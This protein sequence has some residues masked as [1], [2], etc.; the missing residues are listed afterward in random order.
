[1]KSPQQARILELFDQASDLETTEQEAFLQRTCGDDPAL[2]CEVKRLLKEFS[3][4]DEFLAHSAISL[5]TRSLSQE[6]LPLLPGTRLGSYE[7]IKELGRGGM[8]DVFQAR[9][10]IGLPVAIKVLPDYYAQDPERVSRFE[11]EA[12]KMAQLKHPNIAGIHG[13][14]VED[15]W[16]FL[17]LEYVEGETLEARLERGALTVRE[18]VPIFSQIADALSVTHRKD[19]VHRDL[20]PSNIMLT[21]TG[22]VKLLDFGIAKHFRHEETASQQLVDDSM[23]TTL[24]KN[25]TAFGFTPGTLPYM[26]PEQRASEKTD[27]ATDIWAFGV[28]MYEAL[29]GHHP[30]RRDTRDETAMAIAFATPSWKLLPTATP[31]SVRELLKRCLV[32]DPKLRFRDAAEAKQILETTQQD[33]ERGKLRSWLRQIR[34]RWAQRMVVSFACGAALLSGFV[35]YRVYE[36]NAL[37]LIVVPS[38]KPPCQPLQTQELLTRLNQLSRLRVTTLDQNS[39]AAQLKLLLEPQC[40]GNASKALIKLVLP[41]ANTEGLTL[42]AQQAENIDQAMKQLEPVLNAMVSAKTMTTSPTQA[43]TN[44]VIALRPELKPEEQRTLDLDEWDDKASLEDAIQTVR[45]LIGKDGDSAKF[46]AALSRAYMYKFKITRDLADKE[47]ASI[48]YRKAFRLEPE[49]PDAFL[50]AGDFHRILGEPEA[51][52]YF[53]EGLKRRPNDA[54]TLLGLG[55]A[56]E[57]SKKFAQAEE[58]FVMAIILRPQYWGGYNELGLFHLYRDNFTLASVYLGSAAKLS[59]NG[60]VHYSFGIFHQ[61]QGDLK[62]AFASYEDSIKRKPSPEGFLGVGMVRYLEGNYPEAADYFR[63]AKEQ[64]PKL[65]EPWGYWGETLY[66]LPTRRPESKPALEQA[67]F[68]LSE[69]LKNQIEP[70]IRGS[71]YSLLARWQAMAGKAT[72]A[73][74]NIQQALSLPNDQEVGDPIEIQGSAVV[75]FHLIGRDEEAL[76][77]LAQAATKSGSLEEVETNPFLEKLRHHPGY[78]SIIEKHRMLRTDP[79]AHQ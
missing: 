1:M 6:V 55:R 58:A 9:S 65:A 28:V 61:N 56:Y 63:R 20:K 37:R 73:A 11:S 67:T 45:D 52:K 41:Y 69:E 50:A 25:L 35:A 34:S 18:A 57:T 8:G 66:L 46:Q 54:Q 7:I 36:N 16:R 68:L 48:A 59:D 5:V 53:L 43:Q 15:G 72:E 30:F 12:R 27:Q 29:T 24:T 10:D 62:S 47:A 44:L 74:Q 60:T 38:V 21:P 23:L 3:Q 31:L 42:F 14:E 70:T 17:V 26:S 33:L 13:R 75:V 40:D 32:K 49:S 77:W 39:K 78:R 22:Q 19:I 64:N 79:A 71:Q 4:P 2:Y 76:K 51:I